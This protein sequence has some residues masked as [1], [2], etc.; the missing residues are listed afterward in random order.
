VWGNA[1][2]AVGAILPGIGGAAARTGR[3]EVLYAFEVIGLILIWMGYR[4]IVTDPGPSIHRAQK[5]ATEG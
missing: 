3:V 5:A 1:A 4:I 2:I